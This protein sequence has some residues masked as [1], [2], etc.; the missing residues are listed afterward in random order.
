MPLLLLTATTG[1]PAVTP[2]TPSGYPLTYPLD[3][4]PTSPS[5]PTTGPRA[6]AGE[7]LE[8]I[9]WIEPDGTSTQLVQSNGLIITDGPLG[10]FHAP[11]GLTEDEVGGLDGSLPRNVRLKAREVSIPV[12]IL[13]DDLLELRALEREWARRLSPTRGEGKLRFH[14]GDGTAREFTRV[15][16][17]DP[18]KGDEGRAQAS[19]RHQRA[20][21]VFRC[22]DPY[23]YDTV[24]TTRLLAGGDQTAFFPFLP[25]HLT[26]G[27]IGATVQIN[28][29][30]DAAAWPVWTVVG[31]GTGITITNQTTGA[32]LSMPTLALTAG[33]T[34]TIDTRPGRKSVTRN[35]GTNLYGSV[36]WATSTMG[37]LIDGLNNVVVAVGSS[38]SATLA[39][40]SYRRRYLTA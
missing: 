33:Q 6:P 34:L 39:S 36:N 27:A 21:L 9:A 8:S 17:T 24:D 1:A 2:T 13:A 15:I 35:D 31:P 40:V 37:P 32:V 3:Y 11:V 7:G 25:M 10:R 28:N 12:A 16:C 30:G 20:V 26:A 14:L 5:V 38:T 23:G 18:L 19:R 22:L 4:G 29:D